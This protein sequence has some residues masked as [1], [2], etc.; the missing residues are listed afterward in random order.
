MNADYMMCVLF[1]F[2]AA[3]I[4]V[5]G[6]RGSVV[7]VE[8]VDCRDITCGVCPQAGKFKIAYCPNCFTSCPTG[9]EF[10]VAGLNTVDS[11]YIANYKKGGVWAPEDTIWL[12]RVPPCT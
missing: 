5:L 9:E 10:I 12:S 1:L 3:H 2:A 8:I 11:L 7:D 4:R 6:C